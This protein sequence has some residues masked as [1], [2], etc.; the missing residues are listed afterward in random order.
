MLILGCKTVFTVPQTHD[1]VS[2]LLSPTKP[3]NV[4]D[5]IVIAIL[6][7]HVLTILL[8]PPSTRIP[9]FAIL[10][11]FWRTSYDLGIGVLLKLQS[12]DRRLVAWAKKLKLFVDPNT[13]FN[14]HP[15]LYQFIK[16]EL[17][18]KLTSDYKVKDA[19]IEVQYLACLQ[20]CC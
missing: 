18:I 8:L 11:L 6:A 9:V 17:D 10:F 16:R 20:T 15:K 19:P 1:M 3:K 12:S 4:G 14:A 5:L 2:Q 13:A 7:L